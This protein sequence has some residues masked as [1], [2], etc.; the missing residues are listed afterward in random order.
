MSRRHPLCAAAV[1]ERAGDKCE[2][3]GLA[4]HALGFRTRDGSFEECQ[5]CCDDGPQ[6]SRPVKIVLTVH[7]K[8]GDPRNNAM[9]NLIALCQQ[10]HNRADGPMRARHARQT[11]DRKRGQA[12][13]FEEE[14]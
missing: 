13:M 8:D 10:C 2:Q 1:L 9:E 7:H 4:N 5:G 12:R 3:C 6:G 14:R 11:L